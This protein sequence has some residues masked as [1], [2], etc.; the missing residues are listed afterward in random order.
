[1]PETD[2]EPA[3][4]R[5]PSAQSRGL[6]ERF[7]KAAFETH[8]NVE[9]LVRMVADIHSVVVYGLR[10]NKPAVPAQRE[11]ARP[12]APLGPFDIEALARL[13]DPLASIVGR[14]GRRKR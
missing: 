8:R 7:L 4:D 11:A 2:R 12:V 9:Y 14:I 6:A 13:L 10:P 3:D 1:M 5:E